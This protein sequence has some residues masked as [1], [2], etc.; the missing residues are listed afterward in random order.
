MKSK[1]LGAAI[2]ATITTSALAG[3]TDGP[4]T[5]I[6]STAAEL[7]ADGFADVTN[8]TPLISYPTGEC[9]GCY[10]MPAISSSSF[11]TI[12]LKG[13]IEFEISGGLPLVNDGLYIIMSFT[14]NDPSF[15]RDDMISI[16]DDNAANAY[17][18]SYTNPQG[19]AVIN[20]VDTSTFDPDNSILFQWNPSVDSGVFTFG[21][22]FSGGGGFGS[23]FPGL[24]IDDIGSTPAPGA[25]ALL[26]IAGLAGSRRRR[27]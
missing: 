15:T 23:L 10:T 20:W 16:V 18:F 9:E 14:F 5:F 19:C 6:D 17:D 4:Y 11:G 27:N 24:E 21:W 13:F 12:P 26:G 1:I 3:F 25:L 7:T 22:D 2:A 8:G